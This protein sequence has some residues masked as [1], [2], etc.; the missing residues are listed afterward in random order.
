MHRGFILRG[1]LALGKF[2]ESGA[3]SDREPWL[4]KC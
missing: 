1:D 2:L 4:P 3:A